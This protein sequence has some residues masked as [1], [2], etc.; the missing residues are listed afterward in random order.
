MIAELIG[1]L[2]ASVFGVCTVVKKKTPLFYKIIFFAF[3]TC[4]MGGIYTATFNW[5]WP[6]DQSGF[7]V[8]YLGYMGMF[9]FLYSS[10]YGAINTL[11]DDG[12]REFKRFRFIAGVAATAFFIASV[13]TIAFL[14][15]GL[16]LLIIVI[17]MSFTLY[18]AL[19]LL[20]I[21]DV[22]MGIIRV[23]RPYNALII[24]LCAFMMIRILAKT[25][26]M[27]ESIGSICSG[28]IIA[29]CLPIA[30]NGV[31]KWFI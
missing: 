16:W 26:S 14:H 28:L 13:L 6:Q 29:L 5:L 21:P 22:E 9:F 7:H 24:S 20:I 10:Y 23:M 3:L 4:L 19:K 2:A 30:R 15:E 25:G 12:Q 18:F 8:G 1:A 11:A 31:R 17:P 27:L